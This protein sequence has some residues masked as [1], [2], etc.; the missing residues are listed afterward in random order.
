LE[1]AL[2]GD[3]PGILHAV[4]AQNQLMQMETSPFSQG[5]ARGERFACNQGCWRTQHCLSRQIA[6]KRGGPR[7]LSAGAIVGPPQAA[8]ITRCVGAFRASRPEQPGV[9][10]AR[11]LRHAVAQHIPARDPHGTSVGRAGP[12]PTRPYP[13]SLPQPRTPGIQ[14]KPKQGATVTTSCTGGGGIVLPHIDLE[15]RSPCSPSVTPAS[16]KSCARR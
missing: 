16:T 1:L 10:S 2:A 15:I 5:Q 13:S 9:I 6:Q 11:R 4:S 14:T 3:G 7:S 8:L 12:M